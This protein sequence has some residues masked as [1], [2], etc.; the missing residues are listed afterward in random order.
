MLI[1]S[2]SEHSPSVSCL[3]EQWRKDWAGERNNFNKIAWV[4]NVTAY[5]PL[6]TLHYSSL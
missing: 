3:I 1:L 5:L 4:E 6:L 2:E